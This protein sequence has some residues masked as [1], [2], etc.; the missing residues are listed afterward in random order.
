MT[1]GQ[2]AEVRALLAHPGFRATS[3]VLYSVQ[4]RRPRVVS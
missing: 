1:D 4:G 3:C 2:L